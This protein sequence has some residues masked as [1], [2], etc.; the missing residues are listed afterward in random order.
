MFKKIVFPLVTVCL[1]TICFF[2]C[3]KTSEF[4]Q[5]EDN[6]TLIKKAQD[7]LDMREKQYVDSGKI[8]VALIKQNALYDNI[9][10]EQLNAT[11]KLVIIP[12]KNSFKTRNNTQTTSFKNIVLIES[13]EHT[14]IKGD[15]VEFVP[16]NSSIVKMPANTISKAYNNKSIPSD[17]KVSILTLHNR[18]I[19]DLIYQ[20]GKLKNYNTVSPKQN[21]TVLNP[22]KTNSVAISCIDWYWEYYINGVLVGEEYAFTTCSGCDEEESY[23]PSSINSINCGGGGGGG[24]GNN[25]GGGAGS[26][27]TLITIDTVAKILND[28]CFI[29]TVNSITDARIKN[30]VLTMFAQ[31]FTGFGGHTNI[32]FIEDATMVNSDGSPRASKS[33]VGDPHQWVVS[34]NPNY[35]STASNEFWVSVIIHEVEHGFISIYKAQNP[36]LT[37]EEQ[38]EI[39]FTKLIDEM[40]ALIM[41]MFPGMTQH[42]A[43]A[44]ALGGL[45][46]VLKEEV[47]GDY[48]F[49]QKFNAYAL[50]HYNISL[51]DA[52]DTR[53]SYKD[54][55]KGTL[56]H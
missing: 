34:L 54:G 15:I 19:I 28:S 46:Q 52:E 45:D 33:N 25:G 40:S 2:S 55:T 43:D 44:L 5:E 30:K 38:H 11:E 49:I 9:S 53:N 27:E 13:A 18:N 14:F 41:D 10:V 26:Y 23:R 6:S 47:N 3:K 39:M 29:K 4:S 31:T 7:Y 37:L 24:G 20:N 12:L 8:N 35:S 51:Q 1:L 42:D 56:C 36:P 48:V 50:S 21:G 17:G 32:E 22:Y 16:S